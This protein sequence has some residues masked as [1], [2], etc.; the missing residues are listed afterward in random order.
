GDK[1]YWSALGNPPAPS[2]L[3][4]SPVLTAPSGYSVGGMTFGTVNNS[5]TA[6]VAFQKGKGTQGS[7]TIYAYDL[8]AAPASPPVFGAGNLFPT[9]SADTPEFLL[10]VP[11]P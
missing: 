5:A 2:G 4:F 11:V 6:Y 3:S 10:F 1:L 8:G 7:G 9:I